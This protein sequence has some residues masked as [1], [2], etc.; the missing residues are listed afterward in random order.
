[1]NFGG[2]NSAVTA[3]FMKQ[4]RDNLILWVM[5]FFRENL[6]LVVREEIDLFSSVRD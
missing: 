6:L 1:M 4:C 3:L 2:Y 5:F